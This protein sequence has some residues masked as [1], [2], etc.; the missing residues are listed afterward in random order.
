MDAVE[1][2]DVEL[3]KT[4]GTAWIHGGSPNQPVRMRRDL[5]GAPGDETYAAA[6][7]R[8]RRLTD[9]AVVRIS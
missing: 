3:I 7:T 2:K 9:S 8:W 5:S 1:D 6:T 4:L